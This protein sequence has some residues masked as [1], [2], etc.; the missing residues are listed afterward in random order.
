MIIEY[1]FNRFRWVILFTIFPIYIFQVVFFWLTLTQYKHQATLSLEHRKQTIYYSTIN[2]WTNIVSLTYNFFV[3]VRMPKQFFYRLI[4]WNDL[5]FGAVNITLYVYIIQDNKG[6]LVKDDTSGTKI[7]DLRAME[8][9]QLLM[10]GI[11]IILLKLLY[12]LTLIQWFAPLISMISSTIYD[13]RWFVL[14]CLIF[15]Y[16]L[17]ES[18]YIMAQD[19]IQ[20]DGV[21]AGT[22][23]P[24][25]Y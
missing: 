25:S 14:I 12:F 24:Y 8:I 5:I 13:I 3:F 2:L 21:T 9:R 16:C 17:S 22:L 10:V 11:M 1:L 7:Y 20:F 19:Q 6:H 18:F 23:D 4:T 15:I